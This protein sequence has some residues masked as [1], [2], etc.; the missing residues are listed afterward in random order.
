MGINPERC[1]NSGYMTQIRY[2][3]GKNLGFH[4]YGLI[5]ADV[6]PLV[7]LQSVSAQLFK[8]EE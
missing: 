5:S 1:V 6:H 3:T 2:Q 7:V 8:R 4:I